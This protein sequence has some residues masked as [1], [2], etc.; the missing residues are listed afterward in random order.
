MEPVD[1]I[2]IEFT[3]EPC[4]GCKKCEVCGNHQKN[5]IIIC[6]VML[7]AVF[8]IRSNDAT[9]ISDFMHEVKN[10]S[11]YIKKRLLKYDLPT[12]V[13]STILDS[14]KSSGSY[15]NEETLRL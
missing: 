12:E 15:Q 5:G 10:T 4:K 2:I 13:V 9:S 8:C 3:E 7:H 11:D 6:P 1:C 14:L